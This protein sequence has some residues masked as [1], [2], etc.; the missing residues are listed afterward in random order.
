[1]FLLWFPDDKKEYTFI[2]GKQRNGPKGDVKVGLERY[3]G[4]IA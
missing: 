1:M 3:R 4:G 2:I